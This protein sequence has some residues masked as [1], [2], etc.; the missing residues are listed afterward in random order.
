MAERDFGDQPAT[1]AQMRR[2]V[3]ERGE[4]GLREVMRHF[5][6]LAA[7]LTMLW[8]AFEDR[9]A[10]PAVRNY[11]P[12]VFIAYKWGGPEH[13]AWVR[14]LAAEL[15]RRGYQVLLDQDHLAVDASNFAEVPAYIARLVGSDVC[16]VVV[17]EQYLDLVEARQNKT[18][19][20]YDEFDVAA[21]LA[22]HGRLRICALWKDPQV[23]PA[24]LA[25][26]SHVIDARRVPFDPAVLAEDF[27]V[28]AGP[29]LDAAGRD[30]LVRFAARAED[31]LS[32]T[33]PDL[34]AARDWLVEHGDLE[35]L[36]DYQLPL[37]RLYWLAGMTAQAHATAGPLLAQ[38]RDAD[39]ALQLAQVLDTAGAH[40]AMFRFLHRGRQQRWLR[41]SPMLHYFLAETL[42]E[43]GSPVA[44]R[45]HFGWLLASPAFAAFPAGMQAGIRE[46][47]DSLDSPASAL[48]PGHT[49]GCDH[50]PTRY[51]LIDTLRKVC[52][53]CATQYRTAEARCPVCHN[54]G[55]VPLDILT[56][57]GLGGGVRLACPVC[58]PGTMTTKAG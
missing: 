47:H 4:D 2:L 49:V 56:V 31:L 24:R 55:I 28:Y 35:P 30:R 25:L 33:P 41:D 39:G 27:P 57:P 42:F 8:I 6:A 16:L 32:A 34:P 12:A 7:R 5:G 29:V 13:Q 9:Q 43:L 3:R 22:D 17:T 20:V 1:L 44:A 38:C 58:D 50:C 37:C 51:H 26:R 46:R 23:N 18:S 40:P 54:D 19:W 11:P 45:N 15:R 10:L 53:E 48:L 14:D 52:G 36:Y 21:R